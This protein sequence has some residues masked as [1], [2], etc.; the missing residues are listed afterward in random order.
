MGLEASEKPI[1]LDS[2]FRAASCTKMITGIACM[3]LVESGVLQLDSPGQIESLAPELRDVKVLTRAADGSFSLVE[4]TTR[5]TLRMLL[6][7][8]GE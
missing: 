2:V 4:K 3:Q 6:N 7:H 1:T 8:T 5:I